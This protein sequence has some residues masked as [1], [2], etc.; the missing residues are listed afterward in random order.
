M[1]TALSAEALLSIAAPLLRETS[2]AI[3]PVRLDLG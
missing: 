3:L 2:W 1:P